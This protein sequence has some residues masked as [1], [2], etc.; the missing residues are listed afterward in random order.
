M[1]QPLTP[2]SQEGINS[3][4]D[5][6]LDALPMNYE[7]FDGVL[8]KKNVDP[9]TK[10]QPYDYL[11]DLQGGVCP[12]FHPIYG[13]YELKWEDLQTYIDENLKKVFIQP[14]TLS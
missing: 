3:E 8:E 7:D 10:H 14:S 13:L 6:H 11:I 12:L 4:S 5:T 9:Q 2:R 1:T